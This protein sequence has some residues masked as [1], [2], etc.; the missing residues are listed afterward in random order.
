[1]EPVSLGTDCPINLVMLARKAMVVNAYK[2]PCD[3]SS[4]IAYRHYDACISLMCISLYMCKTKL[5][6]PSDMCYTQ[7]CSSEWM[8]QN[9]GGRRGEEREEREERTS[10][11][12]C[13]YE[14]AISHIWP[15]KTRVWHSGQQINRNKWKLCY[16]HTGIRLA[17]SL[18]NAKGWKTEKLCRQK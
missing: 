17:H 1:M 18:I 11:S 5:T 8:T 16:K 13:T 6:K 7:W 9:R 15:F 3:T 4:N 12:T 14:A 10:I 2:N